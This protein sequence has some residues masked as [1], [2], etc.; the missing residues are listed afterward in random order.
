MKSVVVVTVVFTAFIFN[1]KIRTLIS[2]STSQVVSGPGNH[3]SGPRELIK[4]NM[5]QSQLIASLS[6][7]V[8]SC[9]PRLVYFELTMEIKLCNK[10][11]LSVS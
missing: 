1:R 11:L 2:G 5:E 10:C 9:M 4:S 3:P 7:H 8:V 6:Y